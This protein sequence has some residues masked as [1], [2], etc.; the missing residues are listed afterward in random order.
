MISTLHVF[1]DIEVQSKHISK[2]E[3]VFCLY[4]VILGKK[5]KKSTFLNVHY[6]LIEYIYIYSVQ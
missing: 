1:I 5:T 6:G 3:N 2:R 4:W